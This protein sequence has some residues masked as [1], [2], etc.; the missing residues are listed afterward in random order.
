[1]PEIYCLIREHLFLNVGSRTRFAETLK[2]TIE[3]RQHKQYFSAV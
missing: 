2:P 1:M 3:N